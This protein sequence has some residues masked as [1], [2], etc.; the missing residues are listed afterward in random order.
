MILKG[1]LVISSS[2]PIYFCILIFFFGC[3]ITSCSAQ[4]V[5]I[6]PVTKKET[7]LI[8]EKI[9]DSLEHYYVNLKM[10]IKTGKRLQENNEKGYYYAI[11]DPK[12]LAKQL[13]KDLRSVNGDLHLSVE[14]STKEDEKPIENIT[15]ISAKYGA[16]TNY[17]F[18]EIKFIEG[19]IAYIKVSHFSNWDFGNKARQKITEIMGLFKNSD[20]FIIDVRD[21]PGGVPYVASY[22]SSYFFDDKPVHLSDVYTRF[23]DYRYGI[24]TE[25]LV[26]GMKYPEVPMYIL[27]NNKS[28]S[29]AEEFAFW[30]QNKNRA[31]IIGQTTAGAGYG[32]MTHKLNER[33][34]VSISS[35][36]GIDPNSKKGFQTVGVVPDSIVDEGLEYT[37]ALELAKKAIKKEVLKDTDQ[38]HH[39]YKFLEKKQTAVSEVALFEQVMM[40]HQ[41]G[42]LDYDDIEEL[43][44]KYRLEPKKALPILRANTVLYSFYPQPFDT[45]AD[46]LTNA[47]NY[48]MALH[49]YNK[50]IQLAEIKNNPDLDELK[51]NREKFMKKNG[52][53]LG[54]N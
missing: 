40:L 37:T 39:F 51:R 7:T 2:A 33:F 41:L 28:A 1:K 42:H 5:L 8:I 11:K 21:N 26:A 45:Y 14:Y 34:S 9:V 50:A 52:S 53:F 13:T 44:K 20:A 54:D 25:P 30:L 27:V 48:D 46:V 43:G 19:N 22:L 49:Y 36:E 24:F 12:E 31:A 18:Q 6:K 47:K 32:A 35:E 3:F 17:G 16:S 29:A 23:N 4:D 15:R 38:V 10:G